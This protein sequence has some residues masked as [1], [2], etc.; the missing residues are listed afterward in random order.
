MPPKN[1]K[2]GLKSLAMLLSYFD[3]IFVH[4]RQKTRL[5]PELS[6]KL[7]STLGPIQK[8]W[9]DLHLWCCQLLIYLFITVVEVFLVGGGG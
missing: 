5:R 1:R 7:L 9:L 8:L 6:P 4:P 2:L 3:Y